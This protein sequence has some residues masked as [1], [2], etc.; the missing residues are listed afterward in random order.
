MRRRI[1]TR[2]R[3]KDVRQPNSAAPQETGEGPD[4]VRMSREPSRWLRFLFWV[5]GI[6]LSVVSVSLL[7]RILENSPLFALERIEVAGT[8]RASL[9]ELP[10]LNGME[11]AGNLLTLDIQEVVRRL[12]AQPGVESASVAKKF[13]NQL[14][15]RVEE[16]QP[17]ALVVADG[18]LYHVDDTGMIFR[19]TGPGDTLDLPVISGLRRS[20]V[21]FKSG[22]E[23]RQIEKALGLLKCL[24][25]DASVLGS[26]SEIRVDAS[27]GLSFVLVDLPVPVQIGWEDFD[28]RKAKFK[29]IL[30]LVLER[31]DTLA[32]VDLRF[33]HQVVVRQAAAGPDLVVRQEGTGHP[34]QLSVVA[35]DR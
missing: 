30:P 24:E 3:E 1:E 35:S 5:V 18:E 31:Q 13:P 29:R 8:L 26:V 11:P 4:S 20:A 9:G 33:D 34:T 16:R 17:V 19:K 10:P 7:F 14:V 28:A 21:G 23:G 25:L 12:E 6:G 32:T 27:Q 22:P 15:V 2:K